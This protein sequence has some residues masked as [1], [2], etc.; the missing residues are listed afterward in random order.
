MEACTGPAALQAPEVS[1]KH[2]GRPSWDLRPVLTSCLQQRLPLWHGLCE[3]PDECAGDDIY[4][5]RCHAPQEPVE[6]RQ[7]VLADALARPW[8]ATSDGRQGAGKRRRQ[9]AG[10]ACAARALTSGGRALA[11][12]CRSMT[13]APTLLTSGGRA[14]SRRRCSRSSATCPAL[15]RCCR[16]LYGGNGR[17][18][19]GT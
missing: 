9:Q 4:E 2:S 3:R 18:G 12:R 5:Q 17:C 10:A 7:V 11:R 13:P 15:E 14:P 1:P 16:T 8:A 6:E 19:G